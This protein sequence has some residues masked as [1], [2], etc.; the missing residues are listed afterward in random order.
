MLAGK[1]KNPSFLRGSAAGFVLTPSLTTIDSSN[2]RSARDKVKFIFKQK[3]RF[4]NS[5]ASFEN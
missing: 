2:I 4:I 5:G 3:P 1:Y